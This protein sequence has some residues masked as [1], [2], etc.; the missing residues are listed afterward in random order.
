[1]A[2]QVAEI[3]ESEQA[4]QDSLRKPS[5]EWRIAKT[6]G[7]EVEDLDKDAVLFYPR[8]RISFKLMISSLWRDG[9]LAARRAG[10][11]E[12][13]T[14]R[15]HVG[16]ILRRVIPDV[17]APDADFVRERLL[18][19]DSLVDDVVAEQRSRLKRQQATLRDMLHRLGEYV[20]QGGIR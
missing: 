4:L 13:I 19:C 5:L 7:R 3:E 17:R 15:R 2:D 8:F 9:A 20:E 1:M 18:R 11:R 16:R 6:F 12:P 14:D 10:T